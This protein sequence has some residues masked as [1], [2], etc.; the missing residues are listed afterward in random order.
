MFRRVKGD[1]IPILPEQEACP[2]PAR[3]DT[4]LVGYQSDAFSLEQGVIIC[5]EHIDA[6]RDCSLRV[7]RDHSRQDQAGKIGS[8]ERHQNLAWTL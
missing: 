1:K 4:G 7:R 5:F 6:E 3:I 2:D 8:R